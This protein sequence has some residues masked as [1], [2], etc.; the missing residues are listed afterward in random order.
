MKRQDVEESDWSPMSISIVIPL[1]NERQNVLV[2]Y[3]ELDA[4][5][6]NSQLDAEL[7]FV[8]DGSTDGTMQHLKALQARDACVR[9]VQL[10][11]NYGQTAAMQAGFDAASGDIIVTL[12][13][14]LQN[15]PGDIPLMLAKLHEGYDLVHG[16]RKHRQ[17]TWLT[18]KLPSRVANWLISRITGVRVQDLGCTLK[19]M[20]SDI[21]RELELLGEMHRFIPILAYQRGARCAEVVTN[22]RP[23]KY[24]VSKYGLSR[25]LRVILDLIT[26]K[27][28][29]NYL[30][31]PM[32]LFGRLGF[33]SGL[34]G[35]I[36][37]FT[38]VWQKV[39]LG[40]A[41][42]SSSWLTVA[43]VLTVS[44]I[45]LVGVGVLGELAVRIYFGANQQ[46]SYTL[47]T[48]YGF[49]PTAAQTDTHV[50]Q[51]AA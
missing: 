33:W 22:H 32:Q 25:T 47:A 42:Q 26:V 50:H 8:D 20:R 23:R 1:F 12:D 17:D 46:R 11:R 15:D 34:A 40:T 44:G 4:V 7:I 30:H 3:R 31:S 6:R 36:A 49:G 27:F 21:A 14:D 29:L 38:A 13:G 24:G 43:V 16:W 51:D 48:R 45:Q 28:F 41:F 35:S 37:G 5:V 39:M 9:V 18:R 2:L 10:R 19:A